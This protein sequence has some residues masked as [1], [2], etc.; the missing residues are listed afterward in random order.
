MMVF[1]FVLCGGVN[2]RVLYILTNLL[3]SVFF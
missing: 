3:V 1:V 2:K